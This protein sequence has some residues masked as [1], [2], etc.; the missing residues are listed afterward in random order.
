MSGVLNLIN[1]T[2]RGLHLSGGPLSGSTADNARFSGSV[3]LRDDI[4]VTGEIG[5]IPVTGEIGLAG[6]R[7]GGDLQ[8]CGAEIR[9]PLRA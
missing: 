5:L 6:A 7:I 1:A 4:P 2:L 9:A 8:I 3:Y